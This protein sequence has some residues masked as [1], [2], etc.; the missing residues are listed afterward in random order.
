ME[1]SALVEPDHFPAAPLTPEVPSAADARRLDVLG[2]FGALLFPAAVDESPADA[3]ERTEA[4]DNV[5]VGYVTAVV[6]SGPVPE[7]LEV[8]LR[9]DELEAVVGYQVE[10][11]WIDQYLARERDGADLRSRVIETSNGLVDADEADV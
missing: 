8:V 4:V 1:Q 3:P 10:R 7:G 2:D 11:E 9:L 6:I 5:I